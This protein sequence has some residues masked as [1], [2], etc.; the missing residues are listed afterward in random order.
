[1]PTPPSAAKSLYPH[2]PS[3]K[4]EQ[5]WQPRNESVA[6]AMYPSLAPPK[7]PTPDEVKQLWLD[8]MM[9]LSGLR[10]KRT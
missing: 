6:A 3:D 1:M 8:R 10:R 4:S 2:L 9:E 5:R 7:P